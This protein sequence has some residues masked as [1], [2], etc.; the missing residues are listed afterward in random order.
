LKFDAYLNKLDDDKDV[1]LYFT[2]IGHIWGWFEEIRKV[3]R[4]SREFSGKEQNNIATDADKLK[5]NTILVMMKIRG[6]GRKIG[7]NLKFVSEKKYENCQSHMDELFVKIVKNE[8]KIL[9]VVRHN[10][11]EELNHRWSR[12]QSA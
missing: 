3:L 7:A 10:A 8:G 6:E 2:T 12:M 9:D 5:K 11:L 1:K 4:V